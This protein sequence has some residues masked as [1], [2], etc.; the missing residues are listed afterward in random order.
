MSLVFRRFLPKRLF[1]Y[2]GLGAVGFLSCQE[3][4]EGHSRPRAVRV[5]LPVER[6][7]AQN[8]LDDVVV[9]YKSEHN[10]RTLTEWL[11]RRRASDGRYVVRSDDRRRDGL[12]W[13]LRFSRPLALRMP[14]RFVVLKYIRSGSLEVREWR[15]EL[16]DMECAWVCEIYLGMTDDIFLR[17]PEDVAAW[18]I[19]LQD[20]RG[21]VIEK[22]QSFLWACEAVEEGLHRRDVGFQEEVKVPK[23]K[24]SRQRRHRWR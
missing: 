3:D 10:F 22:K 24:E 23:M 1:L 9:C 4:C 13:V 20:E 2:L 6:K 5:V 18:Y 14:Y 11:T 19:E 7:D 15:G 8:A 12:Y 17:S 16:R 21:A